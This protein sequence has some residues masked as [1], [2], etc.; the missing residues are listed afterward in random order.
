MKYNWQYKNWPQFTYDAD[1]IDHI[2][3]E[4]ASET[5]EVKGIVDGLSAEFQQETLLQFM[6][7]EAIKTS[8]IEGEYYSRRDVMSSIKNRLGLSPG[9]EKI[10]DVN[11]RGIAELMVEVRQDYASPLTEKLIKHWHK[12]LFSGSRLI[13]GGQY[14]M[15]V[16]PMVIVSG[17]YG[18][19]VIHYEAPS[20]ERVSSEMEQFVI[21]YDKYVTRSK[22]LKGA[23]V[24]TAIAHLYFE[25][26]HPFE[27]GN[28]RIGRA[29]AEKC[30]SE[31][32]GR[33]LVMSLSTTIERNKK[34]YYD[35]LKAGQRSLEITDWIVYFS[36]TILQAQKHAKKIIRFT[37]DKAKFL[38]KYKPEFNERQMKVILK[39]L[40]RGIEGFEGGMTAKKY[41]SIAKTSKATATRDLQDLV[42]KGTL[43]P[44]GAGRG[45]NY[46][47]NMYGIFS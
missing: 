6:I 32:I 14:R 25:S 41:M 19:E 22:D 31:S 11:A 26:I 4:F 3:L 28:G 20:S 34:A 15:G 21:W 37:L 46:E 29:I 5:G 36:E 16:E 23:L 33:P 2:I 30:L 40:D 42:E 18:R 27:D 47:L 43:Q 9:L 10:K 12:I 7:D 13:R 38:D 1:A 8:E 39:M 35:A 44:K 24:K 17:S 45:V